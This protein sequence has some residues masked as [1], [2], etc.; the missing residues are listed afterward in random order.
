[1][2]IIKKVR[3]NKREIAFIKASIA[4]RG[5]TYRSWASKCLGKRV[6]TM[7]YIGNIM[8]TGMVSQKVYETFLKPLNLPFFEGFKWEESTS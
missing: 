6:R 5:E 4:L 1:M 3:L 7:N 2:T 8:S